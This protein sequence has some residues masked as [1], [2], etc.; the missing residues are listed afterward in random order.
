M[1]RILVFGMMAL[2]MLSVFANGN[3]E[4]GAEYPARDV[5]VIIPWSVGGMTGRSD[6]PDNGMAGRLFWSIVH[7]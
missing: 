2:L 5:K 1:K 3:Q 4:E 6:P 7:C